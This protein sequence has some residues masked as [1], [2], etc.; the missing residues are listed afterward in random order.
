LWAK[1]LEVFG[2]LGVRMIVYDGEGD[3][4]SET[5]PAKYL[6]EDALPKPPFSVGE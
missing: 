3:F 2:R 5:I 4:T 1:L 6:R